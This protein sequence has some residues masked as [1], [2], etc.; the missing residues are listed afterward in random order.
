MQ[1]KQI[2]NFQVLEGLTTPAVWEM[3]CFLRC[4]GYGDNFIFGDK[5]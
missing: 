2:E 3:E 5:S 1:I 4:V